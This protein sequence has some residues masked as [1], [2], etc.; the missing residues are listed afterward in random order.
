[1][2]APELV[3]AMNWRYATKKFDPSRAIPTP[4]W[5]ALAESL[6]LTPSSYGLQPW[7]FVVVTNKE[8]MER[9]VPH[10]WN[11]RQVARQHARDHAF[12]VFIAHLVLSLVPPPDDDVR[13]IQCLFIQTL[14]G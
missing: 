10:S 13:G 8:I 7:K 11:Q 12:G 5:N 14:T 1:M 4:T 9:L 3:A 2:Q 6:V